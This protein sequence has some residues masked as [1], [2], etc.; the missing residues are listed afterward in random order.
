MANNY[1]G[2]I[3][4]DHALARLKERGIKQEDALSA[5]NNPD[6]KRPGTN[7]NGTN[8]YYKN[9]GKQQL[10]VV[11]KKNDR[12]EWVILSVWSRPRFGG[13]AQTYESGN[14]TWNSI[15]EKGLNFLL[16]WAKRK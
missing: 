3:W 1:G 9:Y 10:E 11:S 16:S 6:R 2:V 13:S 8:V 12:G 15:L 14:K 7:K 5:W 4:T